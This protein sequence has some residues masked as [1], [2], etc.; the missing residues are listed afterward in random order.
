[1]RVAVV[2]GALAFLAAAASA[3]PAMPEG[4]ALARRNASSTDCDRD[5]MSAI[6]DDI[7]DSLVAHDPYSLPLAQVYKATENSHPAALGMMT[8]WR[9]VTKACRPNLLAIDT[10]N[11]TAYFALDISE[12]NDAV[13]S[14]LWAR[15]KVVD[16]EITELELYVNRSRGDHGFSFSPE[17]LPDNYKRWMSPPAD[18]VRATR[19]E[20]QSLS[21]ATFDPNSTFAVN[22]SS[23]CQFTEEGWTV[24][25]PGPDGN[26]STTPLSCSWPDIRPSDTRARQNLVIDEKYGIVVTGALIPGI[27]YPYANISAFIPDAL[28][29]A[30]EAQEVWYEEKLAEGGLS[31]VAPT[32]ATGENLQVLQYYNGEL[33]GQQFMIY[34]SG[35]KNESAWVS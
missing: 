10:L 30:Q 33:Q 7:L 5:C 18:R 24:V 31:L 21:A 32:A 3:L 27:V 14:V 23:D 28:S 25:D 17:E 11:G 13:Q 19:A 16:R 4:A 1:M 12:G 20:L 22:I 15:I 26:G 2:A 29:A 35:P 6:V 34:L 9:T 8:L